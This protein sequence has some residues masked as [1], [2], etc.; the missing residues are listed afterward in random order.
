LMG[1]TPVVQR[2]GEPAGRA[3]KDRDAAR[4]AS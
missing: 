4:R 2:T 3:A 1:Q